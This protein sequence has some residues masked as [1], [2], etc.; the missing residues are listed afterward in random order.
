MTRLFVQYLAI[1][2]NEKLPNSIQIAN[3]GRF[4]TFC[5]MLNKPYKWP[6]TNRFAKAKNFRQIWS[7]W[8]PLTAYYCQRRNNNFRY[9]RSPTFKKFQNSFKFLILYS[10]FPQ[11]LL[12]VSCCTLPSVTRCRNKRQPNFSSNCPKSSHNSFNLQVTFSKPPKIST[13]IWA[14]FVRKCVTKKTI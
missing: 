10:H 13:D 4:L 9:F 6:K 7:H 14:T 12:H 3:F 8:S 5:Q 11:K 1:Y 2:S